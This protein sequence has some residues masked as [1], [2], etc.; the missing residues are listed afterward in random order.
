MTGFLSALVLVPAIDHAIK[1]VIL[2]RLGAG[3]LSLGAFGELRVVRT[4]IWIVRLRRGMTVRWIWAVWVVAAA[5][6]VVVT[7]VVPSF[8]L[9]LGLLVGGALSHVLETTARG[10]ISDYVCLRFWPA[11]NLADVALTAGA[12]GVVSALFAAA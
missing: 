8:G 2:G 4:Q 5:A 7:A 1:R 11:F 9:P 10:E 6:S 12:L 3:S